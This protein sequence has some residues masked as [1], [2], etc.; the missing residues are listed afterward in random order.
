MIDLY[1]GIDEDEPDYL[2]KAAS[3]HCGFCSN[4][5]TIF[6]SSIDVLICSE[7]FKNLEQ[8]IELIKEMELEK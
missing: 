6:L 5:A 2:L 7:C 4:E 3:D 1:D 8:D